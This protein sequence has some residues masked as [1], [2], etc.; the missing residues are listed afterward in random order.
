M[1]P[2][3]KN[4]KPNRKL[5]LVIMAAILAIVVTVSFYCLGS[6]VTKSESR[7]EKLEYLIEMQINLNNSIIKVLRDHRHKQ[8]GEFI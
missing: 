6:D 2:N 1:K 5:F 4:P 3:I 8:S 7:I